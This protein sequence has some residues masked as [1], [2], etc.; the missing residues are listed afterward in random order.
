MTVVKFDQ[1]KISDQKRLAR[2]QHYELARRYLRIRD[3]VHHARWRILIMAGGAPHGEVRAIR[4]LMPKAIITAVDNNPTCLEAAIDA[5]VDEVILADLNDFVP[6]DRRLR[7]TIPLQSAEKFDI[8]NL[9][10]CA[11]A[12]AATN[13]IARVYCRLVTVGGVF[14]MTFSYGR[15]VVELYSHAYE[16][17]PLQWT[18]FCKIYSL[19]PVTAVGGKLV[20]GRLLYLFS[21]KRLE[22]L[23]SVVLYR[24]A[25]MPMCS[26]L[27]CS[28]DGSDRVQNISVVKLEPGDFE[29]AV[30]CPDPSLLYDCPEER[31]SA[32]RRKHAAIRA[33]YTRSAREKELL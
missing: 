13:K 16:T 11:S 28:I 22:Y 10:L 2:G 32:L 21:Q 31:I 19:D 18:S 20:S 7:P 9:D 26:V 33:S 8:V 15:D 24:G 5:G 23:R 4:E 14:M 17:S 6:D 12:N 3:G 30:S 25:E 1:S 27:F 29:I